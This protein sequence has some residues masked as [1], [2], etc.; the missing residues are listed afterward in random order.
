MAQQGIRLHWLSP[1]E[2][3]RADPH[4]LRHGR[5][6]RRGAV[7]HLAAP[8]GVPA[9]GIIVLSIKNYLQVSKYYL[10]CKIWQFFMKLYSLIDCLKNIWFVSQ[11]YLYCSV[12]AAARVRDLE[13]VLR[14]GALLPE[15]GRAGLH[16]DQAD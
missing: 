12:A 2:A 4:P 14:K 9:A 10:L 1:A 6:P 7:G 15:R 16:H 3:R 11:K 8:A 5:L 13:V